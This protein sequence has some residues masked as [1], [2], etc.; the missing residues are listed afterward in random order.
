[1]QRFVHLWVT[2]AHCGYGYYAQQQSWLGVYMHTMSLLYIPP[3]PV[4]KYC[5]QQVYNFPHMH[6]SGHALFNIN[7]KYARDMH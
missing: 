3:I 1:M 4:H 5:V 2:A 7:Y 6:G